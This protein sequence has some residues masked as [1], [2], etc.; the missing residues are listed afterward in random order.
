MTGFLRLGR[1]FT[2]TPTRPLFFASRHLVTFYTSK[3][4]SLS[5]PSLRGPFRRLSPALPQSLRSLGLRYLRLNA[6]EQTAHHHS[7]NHH[8]PARRTL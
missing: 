2:T 6:F 7:Q 4:H 1:N 8:I 5:L 3:W